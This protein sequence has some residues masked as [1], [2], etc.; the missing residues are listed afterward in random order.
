V[1][2]W[3]ISRQLWW[4][5]R[6]PVWYDEDGVPVASVEDLEIGAAHPKTGKSIVRQDEDVLD[7]WASSWLWPFATLGWPE[8]TPD[9]SRFYRTQF[10][11]TARDIMYLWVS[12]MVMAAYELLDDLPERERVPFDTCYIHATV[13][14]GQGRRM[15]KS[16]G[17]GIDPIEMIEKYGADA[18]RFSLILLT[19]EGQDVKLSEDRFEMGRRFTNKMWNA[20]RFVLGNLEGERDDVGQNPPAAMEDRWIL[21]RLAATNAEVTA[22]LTAYDFNDAVSALYRFVWND[23]CDWYLELVKSRLTSEDGAGASAARGT[24]VLV[25]DTTLR[26][27]HPVMP[28]QTEVLWKALHEATGQSVGQLIRT[29]W[30]AADVAKRDEA[31]EGEIGVLM[32]LVRAVR[33][34]RALSSLGDRKPLPAVVVAPG[35]RERGVLEGSFERAKA[36]AHLSSLE[37]HAAAERP[38]SSAVGVASGFEVF[39]PLGGDVDLGALGATLERRVEKLRK[40]IAQVAGKL[41]NPG[42]IKGAS[43]ELVDGERQRQV[44]MGEELEMLERNL[45][46]LQ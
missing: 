11:S 40:G 29:S 23:F 38:A 7:T 36:L 25:L 18:M 30:P 26:L 35:E 34:I 9:M 41:N 37:I 1:H 8:A 3:C 14:D 2:D 10:L 44:E 13:L 31:A 42:F 4:G 19:R 27:L 17:N 12:R 21:S 16:L 15:S 32:D 33:S 45:A 6:I 43:A 20:T 39:V 5:H 24:L 22:A 28:F 46:G